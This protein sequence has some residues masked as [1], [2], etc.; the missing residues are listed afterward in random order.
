MVFQGCI[1]YVN[2]NMYGFSIYSSPFFI[3]M[4]KKQKNGK[5]GL[6]TLL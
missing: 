4:Y 1:F 5:S 2:C 3:I 6:H